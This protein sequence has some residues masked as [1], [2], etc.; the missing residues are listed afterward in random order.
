MKYF[1]EA[2]AQPSARAK[3][4]IKEQLNCDVLYKENGKPY[5]SICPISISHSGE[6]VLVG[7]SENDIGVDIEV[8]KPFDKRLIS[9]YFTKSEQEFIKTDDDFFKIWTVKEAFLKLTGEGLKGIT[10]LN[11]VENNQLYIENFNILSFKENGC[12]IAIV[13]K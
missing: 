6:N 10:K 8:I 7:I 11:V 1:L 2:S 3:E 13:Y 4:I 12:I 5:T 9:R